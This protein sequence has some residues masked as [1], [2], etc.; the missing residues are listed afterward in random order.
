MLKLMKVLKKICYDLFLFVRNQ[1]RS[2]QNTGHTLN[3]RFTLKSFSVILK[4]IV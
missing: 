1:I 3:D 2:D 4:K